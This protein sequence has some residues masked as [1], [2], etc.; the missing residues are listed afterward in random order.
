MVFDTGQVKWLQGFYALSPNIQKSRD[1]AKKIEKKQ[2]K[3]R[4]IKAKPQVRAV[5]VLYAKK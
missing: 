2:K 1:R 4:K 5:L 3:P